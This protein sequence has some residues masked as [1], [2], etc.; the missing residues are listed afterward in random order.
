MLFCFQRYLVPRG[1][2]HSPC[3]TQWRK[4]SCSSVGPRRLLQTKQIFSKTFWPEKIATNKQ[5][6]FNKTFFLDW[7]KN[8]SEPS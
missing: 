3:A 8:L 7:I 6:F 2:L 1:G 5:D 4:C